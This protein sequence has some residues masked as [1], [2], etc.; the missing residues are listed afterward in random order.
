MKG[1]EQPSSS[2]GRT[3]QLSHVTTYILKLDLGP[4]ACRARSSAGIARAT[5]SVCRTAAAD[6]ANQSMLSLPLVLTICP[7]AWTV[8]NVSP[9]APRHMPAGA[10]STSQALSVVAR[11]SSARLQSSVSVPASRQD[12][13]KMIEEEARRTALG[14]GPVDD[15]VVVAI[16]GDNTNSALQK[17]TDVAFGPA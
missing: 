14:S 15:E 7:A 8:A 1:K 12:E 16:V 9:P 11:Y 3:Y 6:K 5:P 4:E 13:M 10:L 2:K 17:S